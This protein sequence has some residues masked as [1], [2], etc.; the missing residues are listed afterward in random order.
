MSLRFEWHRRKAAANLKKHGVTF[1]EAATCF[2]DFLSL[3][4]SDPE[5]STDEE[6]FVML[7]M[8]R[9]GRLLVVIHTVRG[10]AIRILSAR[11]ATARER[12]AYEEGD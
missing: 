11:E 6:R 12:R 4:I 8:S 7:G 3:T 9:R 2:G 10:N 1:S 5:H